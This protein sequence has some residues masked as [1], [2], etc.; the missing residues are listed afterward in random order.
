MRIIVNGDALDIE[1]GL[2]LEGLLARIGKRP[3]HVAVEYNGEVLEREAFAAR[4]LA[5][6]ARIEIVHFVGGG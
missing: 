2:T 1:A 3:D 6:Q 5:A 4:R